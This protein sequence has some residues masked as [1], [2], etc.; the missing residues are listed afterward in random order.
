[1]DGVPATTAM[2]FRNGAVAFQ[3]VTTLLMEFVDEHKG[4]LNDTIQR[5]T[6]PADR[7]PPPANPA[8]RNRRINPRRCRT[9]L[10]VL[11]TFT[12]DVSEFCGQN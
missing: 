11:T 6:Y 4:T 5:F 12:P 9:F 1:M 3:Y 10:S 7:L 8:R 2:H